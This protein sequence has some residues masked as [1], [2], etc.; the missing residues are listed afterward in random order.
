MMQRFIPLQF[1][2]LGAITADI[3]E[4]GFYALRQWLD[5]HHSE[6]LDEI[7]IAWADP[8]GTGI[9]YGRRGSNTPLNAVSQAAYNAAQDRIGITENY[10]VEVRTGDTL[11][12]RIGIDGPLVSECA[13]YLLM[14]ARELTLDPHH[15]YELL[16][17]LVESELIERCLD[18]PNICET[19]LLIAS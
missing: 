10:G 6:W 9:V 4:A 12:G 11:R 18:I 17:L 7:A 3:A 15:D 13:Y 14:L 2:S 19:A 1:D 5:A 8:T 16:R